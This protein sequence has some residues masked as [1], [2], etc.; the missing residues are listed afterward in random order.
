MPVQKPAV[1]NLDILAGLND[2]PITASAFDS[3]V[4]VAIV[5]GAVLDQDVGAVG[6][7]DAVRVGGVGRG[8]DGQVLN[9][10]VLA[11]TG[12]QMK[13]RRINQRQPIDGYVSGAG[14]VNQAWPVQGFTTVDKP[15][16]PDGPITVNG[17]C[18]G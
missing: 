12:N 16:P 8:G 7:V 6:R 14:Q 15:L 9:R 4:I 3:N 2:L 5:N 17:T 13:R 1:P 18:P 10:Y 11:L